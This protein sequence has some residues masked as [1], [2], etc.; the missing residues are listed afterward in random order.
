M[1]GQPQSNPCNRLVNRFNWVTSIGAGALYGLAL[2]L[3]T[4]P[5]RPRDGHVLLVMSIAFLAAGPFAIGYLAI[6]NPFQ[7]TNQS[8]ASWLRAI[9]LPWIA[10]L[11]TSLF[12]TLFKLEGWICIVFF[13][14]IGFIFSSA[15]GVAAKLVRDRVSSR[16]RSTA[17][18]VALLPLLLSVSESRVP[19]PDQ[20]R[21][22]TTE[23]VIHAGPDTVWQNIK[24]VPVIKAGE[25][26]C[27]WTRAI[28]FPRPVEATLSKETVG[29]VRQASFAGGVIF[30]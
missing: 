1:I 23:I 21:T 22:V 26:P 11:V 18:A 7:S 3:L 5:M 14:P 15:G 28:G 20:V 9:F 17:L 27:S 24:S 8:S 2:R 6:S 12:A 25:L 19:D 30:H 13:L 16:S 4:D 29:G 10:I